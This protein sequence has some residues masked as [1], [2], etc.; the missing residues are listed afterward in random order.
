MCAL[1]TDSCRPT[2][3]EAVCALP[4][5]RHPLKRQSCGALCAAATRSGA[6]AGL[7]RLSTLS[8]CLRNNPLPTSEV[9]I[10]VSTSQ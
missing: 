5:I 2:F 10:P 9:A 7:T 6:E 8:R 3:C 1:F 4:D